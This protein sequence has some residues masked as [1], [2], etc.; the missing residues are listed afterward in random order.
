MASE[1]CLETLFWSLR[2]KWFEKSGNEIVAWDILDD[3][4]KYKKYE[5]LN[6]Y[7]MVE[8]F[9]RAVISTDGEDTFN[10]IL[11]ENSGNL[12]PLFH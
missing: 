8:L 9:K 6:R 5:C 1:K 11:S 7:E 2:R 10:Y 3:I 4:N 12:L